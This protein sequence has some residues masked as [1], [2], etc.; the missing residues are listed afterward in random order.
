MGK[1]LRLARGCFLAVMVLLTGCGGS[2]PSFFLKT[3]QNTVSY[4]NGYYH[5][6]QRY[7]EGVSAVEK[8]FMPPIDGLAPLI[9][10]GNADKNKGSFGK[11]D[12]AIKKC[13]VIL[14]RRKYTDW[15]DDCRLLNGKCWFYKGDYAKAIQNFEYILYGPFPNTDLKPEAKLWLAKCSYIQNNPA[16]AKE[17]LPRLAAA[18]AIGKK[19]QLEARLLLGQI[20]I[21]EKDYNTG[22]RMIEQ[23]LPLVKNKLQRARLHFTLAQLYDLMKAFPKAQENYLAVLKLNVDNQLNFQSKLNSADLLARY[24]PDGTKKEAV[25]KQ[26]KK[27]LADDKY[28]E[29]QDQLYY[30]LGVLYLSEKK[31]E[32]EGLDYLKKAIRKSSNNRIKVMAFYKLGNYYFYELKQL[33]YAQTYYDSAAA[34]VP[35]D[36]PQFNEIKEMN[37]ILR[38]YADYK[39]T[40]Q[41]GDSLLD[42]AKLSPRELDNRIAQL[43]KEEDAIKAAI[44]AEKLQQEAM[45]NQSLINSI[46]PLLNTGSMSGFY[47]DNMQ[48]VAQGKMQFQQ[49]WGERKN[50]DNW[51]RKNKEAVF[52]N[53]TDTAQSDTAEVRKRKDPEYRKKAKLKEVPQTPAQQDSVKQT[54]LKALFGLGQLLAEKL[55]VPEEAIKSFQEIQTRAPE[56]E[57]TARAWYAL[58]NL[59]IKLKEP[60]EAEKYKNLVFEKFPK[61]LYARLLR[62]GKATIESESDAE[63]TIYQAL[64]N[65]YEQKDYKTAINFADYLLRMYPNHPML[66]HVHYLRAMSYG[67]LEQKDSLANILS[68][69]IKNW[70][71]A[72][73]TPLAEKTLEAMR[74]GVTQPGQ[75]VVAADSIANSKK[76]DPRLKGWEKKLVYGQN[77]SVL[78]AVQKDKIQQEKLKVTISDFNRKYYQNEKLEIQVFSYQNNYLLAV[79]GPFNSYKTADTYRRTLSQEQEVMQLLTKPLDEIVFL[80]PDNFRIAY[81]NQ[82]LEDYIVYFRQMLPDFLAM[83]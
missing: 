21:E 50:E 18:D 12:E 3:Y 46:D 51:R 5:A 75:A 69:V 4:F 1:N 62:E 28:T 11:F 81:V 78:F 79:I 57:Y 43:L 10:Y 37:T 54:I 20:A 49:R 66:S 7:K 29:F 52:V 2:K 13:D 6:K 67:G 27:L 68:Y 22:I 8:N 63:V 44:E 77:A 65:L 56:S 72:S 53:V 82:R 64:F 73:V 17:Q 76:E 60:Q 38:M 41:R 55:N 19:D 71:K 47:F 80:N 61:S 58:Y 40:I 25:I 30:Q 74:K 24:S 34:I 36:F 35:Q 16:A 32:K 31:T 48:L 39:A 45:I 70:P 15:N 59:Y 23:A 26:L 14:F 42:L 33:K 83:P 9:Y